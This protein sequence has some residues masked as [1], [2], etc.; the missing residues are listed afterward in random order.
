[1]QIEDVHIVYC[2]GIGGIG[3]SAIARYLYRKGITV[4]GYDQAASALTDR[5]QEEG[6]PVH[7]EDAIDYLPQELFLRPAEEVMVVY[8]PAIPSDHRQLNYLR[9][10]GVTLKK[11]AEVLGMFT[12]FK[13][14]IAIAGTHGKTTVSSL[15]AHIVM[16]AEG[17]CN[18][19]L[20]GI[21]GNY[22]TNMLFSEESQRMVVE[23][24]E[25]DHSFLYLYP[26]YAIITNIDGDHFDV[27]QD[28][29]GVQHS[30]SRFAANIPGDGLLVK[31]HSITT[32]LPTKGMVYTYALDDPEADF[33][34]EHLTI[35]QGTYRFDLVTPVNRI[36]NLTIALPGKVNVENAIAACSVPVLL[37]MDD[38][39]IRLALQSFRGVKR[40]FDVH[41]NTGHFFYM[42]DY[43]H[44][45]NEIHACVQAVRAM[46]PDKPVTGVFQPHLYSR[47]RDFAEA[48]A[49]SLDQLDTAILTEIYPARE[50]PLPGVSPEMIMNKMTLSEKY[51]CPKDEVV[52]LVNQINPEVLITMGAGDIDQLV[53][54]FCDFFQKKLNY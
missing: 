7:H 38:Q 3:M 50:T 14:C 27:Y 26:D 17:A 41:I 35:D 19:F 24:D 16:H 15:S 18:A 8:T 6:I 43:A 31:H 12:R 32:P 36:N 47:T 11:R 40:R 53:N 29:S 21:A 51:Y 5:L 45:P 39:A 34:A 30:F 2:I 46:F 54:S 13:D 1:M 49:E 48:F 23:A 10:Q 4:A 22:S 44:L 9:Q 28:F 37:G 52:D 33:Y 25:Y 42:D 20:G